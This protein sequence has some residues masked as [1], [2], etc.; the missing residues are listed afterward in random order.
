MHVKDNLRHSQNEQD[1]ISVV[2]GQLLGKIVR[3]LPLVEQELLR[4]PEYPSF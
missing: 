2:D 1:A 4:L 3:R